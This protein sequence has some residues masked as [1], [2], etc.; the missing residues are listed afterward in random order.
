MSRARAWS[1]RA[2]RGTSVALAA[3]LSG[4]TGMFFQPS[5]EL[6]LKPEDT[7]AVYEAVSFT[8]SDG[9]RLTGLFFPARRSPAVGTVVHFHGNAENMT[10]H[11]LFASWLVDY[12]FNVFAFD[13]RGYGA[14]EGKPELKGAIEDGKA[15]IAYARSRKGVEPER[16]VVFAQSLGGALAVASLAEMPGPVVRAVALD[17]TFASYSGVAQDKIAG[18]LVLWPI[19]WPLARLL[20]SSRYN[21][22]RLI[23][24]LPRVPLLFVH[25][26]ADRVVPYRE[27]MALF[28]RAPEP[29]ELWRVAGGGH[30]DAF[31][32]RAGSYRPKLAEFFRKALDHPPA[33]TVSAP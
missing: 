11:F 19:Q 9:T 24:R 26:T 23:D 6:L 3:A 1:L 5:R 4:C 16:L 17:S 15:A 2:L 22:A 32:R 8:S 21:P 31:A 13:Y 25:G 18:L 29:K 7:G 33:G 28:A 10:T 12:G 30:T 14:S 27:G 20:F